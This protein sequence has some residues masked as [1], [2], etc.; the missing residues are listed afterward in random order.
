MDKRFFREIEDVFRD[1]EI[2]IQKGFL[3]SVF[4]KNNDMTI[5]E[6]KKLLK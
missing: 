1:A 3:V 6:A 4:A 5:L 2:K